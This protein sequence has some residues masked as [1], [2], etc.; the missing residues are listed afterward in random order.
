MTTRKHHDSNKT[1]LI[2]EEKTMRASLLG[3][4]SGGLSQRTREAGGFL[5]DAFAQGYVRDRHI[6]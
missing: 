1:A 2:P 6:V 5:V 3:V 4:D